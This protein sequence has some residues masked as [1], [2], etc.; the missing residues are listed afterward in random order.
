[1]TRTLRSKRLR[2]L[3][4]HASGGKCALC[5]KELGDGWHADHIVPWSVRK[6]TN[7]FNMQ[8]TCAVCNLR[9]GNKVMSSNKLYS[10]QDETD[11]LAEQESRKLERS[12]VVLDVF[13]G[14]GKTGCATLF[15]SRMLQSGKAKK[16]LWIVPQTALQEQV[17]DSTEKQEDRDRFMTEGKKFRLQV[18]EQDLPRADQDGLVLTY[19]Q[20]HAD[21]SR[22]RPIYLDFV[23]TWKTV[24]IADELH[25][26]ADRGETAAWKRALSILLEEPN[27]TAVCGMTGTSERHDEYP[28]YLMK[29]EKQSDGKYLPK[30]DVHC[31]LRR[32]L[33]AKAVVRMEWPLVDATSK[34]IGNNGEVRELALTEAEIDDDERKALLTAI[35]DPE[36]CGKMLDAAGSKLRELRQF[37]ASCKGMVFAETQKHARELVGMLEARGFRAGLAVC[38][39]PTA[40]KALNDFK[41]G[42][43]DWLVTVAMAGQGFDVPSTKVLVIL[44]GA[45]SFPYQVQFMGRGCRYDRKCGVPWEKQV[46]Y[47]FAPHDP[48]MVAIIN[49]LKAEQA[50]FELKEW[51]PGPKVP[52][53]EGPDWWPP[54][55]TPLSATPG[56]VSFFGLDT[57][58][59]GEVAEIANDL[60]PFVRADVSDSEVCELVQRKILER[61]NQ[62][63]SENKVGRTADVSMPRE[64]RDALSKRRESL[65]RKCAALKYQTDGIQDPFEKVQEGLIRHFQTEMIR[66]FG[67][68]K[69]EL[70]DDSLRKSVAWIEN[71][72][73][74]LTIEKAKR[75]QPNGQISWQP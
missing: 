53:P 2:R 13:P 56:P 19:A 70:T 44:N 63:P 8:A 14:A 31:S 30:P 24:A 21:L 46:A 1:M 39:E 27:V 23:R 15:A 66:L 58:F 64:E 52:G 29:Y 36:F 43:Y 4:F 57:E 12:T 26:L 48:R 71:E 69:H 49:K 28:V 22:G 18:S 50:A 45:R 37:H 47:I 7:I 61:K 75:S 16:V 72:Y 54:S 41:K 17:A 38:D 62:N 42:A 55:F 40:H 35:Q 33:A 9:K 6:E 34:W 10:W 32:A 68:R 65:V 67:G 11:K 59:T 3:L 25:Q 73:E 20:L 60:R 74:R 5:G 51:I